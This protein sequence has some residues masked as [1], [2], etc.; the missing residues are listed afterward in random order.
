[1]KRWSIGKGDWLKEFFKE[2]QFLELDYESEIEELK[3]RNGELEENDWDENTER[4][5]RDCLA[6][7]KFIER[8]YLKNTYSDEDTKQESLVDILDILDRLYYDKG[9]VC[10]SGFSRGSKRALIDY[11]VSTVWEPE[12]G[13]FKKH[14]SIDWSF[15]ILG[16]DNYVFWLPY[17]LVGYNDKIKKLIERMD[18]DNLNEAI[19]A[20]RLDKMGFTEQVDWAWVLDKDQLFR[21]FEYSTS[22]SP[23]EAKK[24]HEEIQKQAEFYAKYVE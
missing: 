24:E 11:L 1:M 7:L 10:D 15:T 3:Y 18:N 5:W 20:Y 22:D 21:D 16:W 6:N 19:I 23:I 8:E 9:C 17:K 13:Y 12:F 4:A 2:K 14:R